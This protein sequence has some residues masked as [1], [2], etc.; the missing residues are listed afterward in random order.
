M[1]PYHRL[2]LAEDEKI[3]RRK[4]AEYALA[5]LIVANSEYV[6]KTFIA[7]GTPTTKIIAVPTGCPPVDPVGARS[8]A[9]SDALRVL[10]VGAMTLRKGFP[11]LLEAWRRI[12]LGTRAQLWIAGDFEFDLGRVFKDEPSIRYFGVLSKDDLRDVYRQAGHPRSADLVRGACARGARSSVLWLADHH[13]RG[14]RRRRS[15]A[16]GENGLIIPE[17]DSN[18]LASALEY[19]VAQHLSLPA[20]GARSAERAKNWTVTHSNAAHMRGVQELLGAR[21]L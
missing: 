21:G 8:G 5:D 1:T 12:A 16:N 19:A 2:L 7:N 13:D 4:E 17:G 9:G 18:A 6:R 14:L 3:A 20:M 10:Y 15:G 11:Y